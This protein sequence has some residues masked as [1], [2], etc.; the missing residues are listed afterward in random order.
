MNF[1]NELPKEVHMFQEAGDLYE[2]GWHNPFLKCFD[3]FK[4]DGDNMLTNN[5]PQARD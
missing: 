3:H 2:S 4:I 5:E 1:F